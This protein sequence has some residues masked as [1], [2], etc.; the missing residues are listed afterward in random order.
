MGYKYFSWSVAVCAILTAN[1]AFADDF[2]WSGVY[3]GANLAVGA[4]SSAWSDIVVPSDTEQNLSGE[5]TR[6]NVNGVG[7]GIQLGYQKQL[8]Q[9]VLGVEARVGYGDISGSSQCVGQY[10]DYSAACE[11]R[12]KTT[13]AAVARVGFVPAPKG[14]LY[15]TGGLAL[16]D[17]E[18][19]PTSEHG[20][21][22]S[23][24]GY[25][26]SS[27]WHAGYLVG[28]GFEYALDRHLS[29]GFEYNYQDFGCNNVYFAG[30]T[31]VNDYNPDFSIA[32]RTHYSTAM[33]RVN[34]RF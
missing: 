33:L 32:A 3:L 10:G 5:F 16:A 34:Y 21:Y 1:T 30:N 26:G 15:L 9:V 23:T 11:T 17:V 8:N 29:L 27:D 28:G 4:G 31:P 7:G 12:I 14:L 24:L 19:K 18:H 22:D 13:A 6:H 25:Q 20:P 2:S